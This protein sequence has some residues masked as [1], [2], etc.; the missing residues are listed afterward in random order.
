[1]CNSQALWVLGSAA[2]LER[3]PVWAALLANARERGCVIQEANARCFCQC[4]LALSVLS[5]FLHLRADHSRAN[6][7]AID[8]MITLILG[9]CLFRG[10][11]LSLLTL[12][13]VV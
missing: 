2:T 13:P 8:R 4:F 9:A 12:Q 7:R 3:N 6:L 1:M 5:R 10:F 11:S